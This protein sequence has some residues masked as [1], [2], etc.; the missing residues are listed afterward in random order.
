L[1]TRCNQHLGAKVR[2]DFTGLLD[3]GFEVFIDFLD[4]NV[5]LEIVGFFGAF[6]SPP[7]DIEAGSVDE[8]FVVLEARADSGNLPPSQQEIA[9][10]ESRL[11]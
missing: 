7:E 11:R 8:F 9:H 3:G 6:V 2:C 10:E 4:E 5:G 1:T